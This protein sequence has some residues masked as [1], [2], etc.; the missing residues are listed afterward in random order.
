SSRLLDLGHLTFEKTIVDHHHAEIPNLPCGSL[1]KILPDANGWKSFA[2]LRTW[3]GTCHT[4]ADATNVGVGWSLADFCTHRAAGFHVET[5]GVARDKMF[6]H[7]P[8]HDLLLAASRPGAH[9]K[10]D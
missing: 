4:G 8:R 6:I 9:S 10:A 5:L 1:P 3:G 7:S 2:C